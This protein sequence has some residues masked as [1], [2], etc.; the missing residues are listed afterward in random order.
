MSPEQA[1]GQSVDKRTDIWAFGCVL[2]EMLTGRAA[3]AR[4]T[5]SDTIAAILEQRTGLARR[6]LRSC[7][8]RSDRLLQALSRSRNR[9][10][11]FA[12]LAMPGWRSTRSWRASAHHRPPAPN[13][14]RQAG[15]A[16]PRLAG[17]SSIGAAL[18]VAGLVGAGTARFFFGG[19]SPSERPAQFTLSFAGQMADV[20]DATVPCR[21]PTDVISCS[22]AANEAGRRLCGFGRW[23]PRRRGHFR[24]PT[25]AN[26]RSGHQTAGGSRSTQTASSRRFASTADSRRR[27]RHSG[28]S[29]GGL[30]FGR[31]HHFPS[32]QPASRCS[33]SPNRV[34]SRRRSRS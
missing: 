18:I 22:S 32:E 24:A 21:H 10:G 27:L 25:G 2:Y 15:C 11:A 16:P 28:V 7:R 29:G 1:R 3:F 9:R 30:G 19:G 14:P 20:A 31:R 4:E 6:L 5:I 23:I 33:A 34:E 8:R 17:G 13:S 12:T 26:R